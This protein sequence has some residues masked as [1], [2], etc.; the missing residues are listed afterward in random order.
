LSLAL[1]IKKKKSK[2]RRRLDIISDMLS[3]ARVEVRK[4][5]IMYQANLSYGQVERY[6]K[7]LLEN[8]LVE[9]RNKSFYL[10]TW[11]GK[12]FLQM[13]TDYLD[14]CRQICDEIDVVLKDKLLLE[15][16]CSNNE[17]NLNQTATE[18]EMRV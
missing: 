9:C 8:G 10:I 6:L 4:T 1:N 14:R 15:T 3:V 12:E 17:C 11:K 18:T 2:N 7:S 5:K 16:I 13:Y